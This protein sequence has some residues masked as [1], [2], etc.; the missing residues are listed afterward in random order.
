MTRSA[1]TTIGTT[2]ATAI[3]PEEPKPLLAP[4]PCPCTNA[5]DV[6]DE[7]DDVDEPVFVGVSPPWVEVLK[8]VTV[9][10][11]GS[12]VVPTGVDDGGVET[13]GVGVVVGEGVLLDVVGG[14]VD[15]ELI[16]VE[17]E[18]GEGVLEGVVETEEGL[19]L[20]IE[21]DVGSDV[22][23]GDDDGEEVVGGTPEFV[24]EVELV[25]IVNFLLNTSF[26][27][28]LDRAMSAKRHSHGRAMST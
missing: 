13:V 20:A 27:G 7:D 28:C 11:P 23:V 2:T 5:V 3:V 26:L 4:C 12:V 17:E 18:E 14:V 21:L 19:V 16:I 10:P 24:L 25:A 22:L 1:T 9:D 8:M 6:P 15:E